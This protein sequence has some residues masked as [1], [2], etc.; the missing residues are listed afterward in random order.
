MRLQ[1]RDILLLQKVSQC[2]WLTT[3]QIQRLFFSGLSLDFVRKRLGKLRKSHYLSRF[4]PDR[5]SEALHGF[6]K[7]P[8]HIRHLVGVNEIRIALEE[9]DCDFFYAYWELG[10]FQWQHPVVPDAVCKRGRLY[11]VEYDAG[12]ESR[13]QLKDKFEMY[14]TLNF[15]FTL[16]LV[17][18]TRR[19]LSTLCNLVRPIQ[20]RNE[21]VP[22][23]LE[24]I[25][26]RQQF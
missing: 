14:A 5:M 2:R 26:Q 3:S 6:G 10:Q 1:A 17:A 24:Q 12:T 4:Q 8:T 7:P 13:Q 21:F 23:L 9:K 15:A 25:C 20:T 19:R 16:L 11:L 22:I 18:D